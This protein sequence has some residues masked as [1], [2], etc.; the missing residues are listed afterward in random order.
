[1]EQRVNDLKDKLKMKGY[2]KF[3]DLSIHEEDGTTIF[4]AKDTDAEDS[5]D[6]KAIYVKVF[7]RDAALSFDVQ[8]S[9]LIEAQYHEAAPDFIWATNDEVNYYADCIESIPL[10]EIPSVIDV[11]KKEK[12]P[13]TKRE[14]WS[15]KTY[16]TLQKKFD[17]LHELLYG[18]A[19]KDN[20]SST[21][22]AID[23][24]SKFLFMEIFRLHHPNYVLQDG[25]QAGLKLLEILKF[26]YIE[27]NRK[28]AVK[29]IRQAFKE[30]K[31]HDDYVATNDLGEKCYI[32]NED[33][34][35]K[36]ENPTNYIAAFK[37]FQNLGQFEDE[38]G[39][40]INAT[41]KDVSGDILGRIFDVLMRGKYDNKV[42]QATY[43]TPRPVTEAMVEMVFH[44][45]ITNPKEA[46]KILRV[47]EK[48]IPTF[49]ILDGTCGSA[50]FEI[51]AYEVL[52]RYILNQFTG[53]MKDRMQQLFELMKEHTFVGADSSRN[54]VLKARLNMAMHGLPK[55]PIFWVDNSLTTAS[56][57]LEHYDIVITNPP[58]G[59]GSVKNTTT[60]GEAIL[61]YY[62]SGIDDHGKSGRTG[63]CLGAKPNANGIW[64]QVNATDQAVLFI[65]RYL[66]LLKPGGRLIIVLPDGILSNS[67]YKYVREYIMGKKNEVTGEFEGGRAVV[68]AV[69]SLPTVTFQLSGTGAKTSFLYIKK[70]EH[71]N[72]KQ[73][74]VFM[75]VAEEIGFDVKNKHE[76]QLGNDRNDLLKIVEAYKKG[77]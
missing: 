57:E 38:N 7:A 5:P 69:V 43:L 13:L 18:P 27:E 68:K 19:G 15:Q 36:L 29:Q 75:A 11:T 14:L 35:I 2:G 4:L 46:S 3:S 77:I 31:N 28:E 41:L 65:D 16:S 55:A 59:A 6:K 8:E 32:F 47:D 39:I 60:E 40:S 53:T 12:K 52:K 9:A 25:E 1:M 72:E 33:E 63:L 37:S 56:L 42:G 34:Y 74:P 49:R 45:I 26:E 21:N 51:K 70:K 48:G 67:G 76:V 64:K 20:I 30:I 73:G 61:N 62:T 54:M 44:D 17:D 50:G 24:L 10:S 22:E 66:Q 71:E 23:E 58:F